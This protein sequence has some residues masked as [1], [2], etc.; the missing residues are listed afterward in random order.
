MEKS[1]FLGPLNSKKCFFFYKMSVHLLE[2]IAEKKLLDRFRR[3]SQQTFELGDYRRSQ[4]P[5]YNGRKGQRG[6][7]PSIGKG[8]RGIGP[9]LSRIWVFTSFVFNISIT[10]IEENC[11]TILLSKCIRKFVPVAWYYLYFKLPKKE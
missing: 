3:N 9:R 7:R 8:Q 4:S 5:A 2:R 6:R 11:I 10:I 1:V